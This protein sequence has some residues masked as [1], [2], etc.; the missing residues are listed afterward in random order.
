MDDDEFG[1]IT[2]NAGLTMT[3]SRILVFIILWLALRSL[4]IISAVIASLAFGLAI[5]AS[6]GFMHFQALFFAV[7]SA[8]AF[9]ASSACPLA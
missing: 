6:A 2:H 7:L 8:C 3:L 5:S 1:T 9:S 4:R